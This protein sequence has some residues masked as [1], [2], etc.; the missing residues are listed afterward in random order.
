MQLELTLDRSPKRSAARQ[1]R[2]KAAFLRRVKRVAH[3]AIDDVDPWERP[4][5]GWHEV[6]ESPLLCDVKPKRVM[7]TRRRRR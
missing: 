3:F 2:G 6:I 5:R 4:V 1:A 7:A